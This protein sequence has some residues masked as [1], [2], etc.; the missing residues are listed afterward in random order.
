MI[1]AVA[2]EPLFPEGYNSSDESSEDIDL[3]VSEND[4]ED[5]M[6]NVEETKSAAVKEKAS[7]PT[8][9]TPAR[10]SMTMSFYNAAASVTGAVAGTLSP[11]F[12]SPVSS[13]RGDTD[14]N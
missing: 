1:A 12:R 5:E 13:P 2:A 7:A 3:V 8:K 6:D 10:P 9:E 14:I 4:S 11:L